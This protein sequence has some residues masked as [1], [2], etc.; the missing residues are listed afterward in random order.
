[1]S[2]ETETTRTVERTELR[3]RIDALVA[4]VAQDGRV[5]IQDSGKTVAA[6]VSND[7][8]RQLRRWDER[9]REIQRVL[10]AMGEPF[11]DVPSEEIEREA[12]KALAEVRAE[13]RAAR[14]K[15]KDAQ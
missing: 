10:D 8:L 1:M 15:G 2:I 11:K 7:D 6:L 14:R 3:D 13:R 9:K 4:D 12:E 5:L